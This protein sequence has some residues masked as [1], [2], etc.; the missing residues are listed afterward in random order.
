[1]RTLDNQ[2]SSIYFFIII[3]NLFENAVALQLTLLFKG[4]FS[5]YYIIISNSMA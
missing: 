5:Y 2:N 1:M 4:S 3:K